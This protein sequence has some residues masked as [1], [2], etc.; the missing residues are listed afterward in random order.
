MESCQKRT[1]LLEDKYGQ[2]RN[3][4][5][6]NDKALEKSEHEK[7]VKQ[8]AD[9]TDEEGFKQAYEPKNGLHQHYD[10]MFIAGA[11]D[12]PRYRIDCFKLPMNGTSN[13]TERG[14]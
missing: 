9:I 2:L 12:F 8:I 13:K 10:K 14:S 6:L 4:N 3:A 1:I 11:R 5:N 7:Y